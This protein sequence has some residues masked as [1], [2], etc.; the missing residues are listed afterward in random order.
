MKNEKNLRKVLKGNKTDELNKYYDKEAELIEGLYNELQNNDNKNIF[1]MMNM[2]NKILEKEFFNDYYTFYLDKYYNNIDDSNN[3]SWY[4]SSDKVNHK[5]IRFLL[6]LRFDE[7]NEKKS[8][9]NEDK[10]N[11]IK[12]ILKK[13]CWIESNIN[14]IIDILQI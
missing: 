10:D 7:D 2:I 8:E 6:K 14:N 4:V 1:N 13:I 11:Y 3:N 5:I 9:N 12:L